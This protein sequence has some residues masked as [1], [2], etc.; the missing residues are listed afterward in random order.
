MA[1]ELN[2]GGAPAAPA[3]WLQRGA[4]VPDSS[5]A[6]LQ[7]FFD[8]C[9]TLQGFTASLTFDAVDGFLTALAALPQPPATDEWLPQLC[10]D[11]FDRAF[12][13][14]ESATKARGALERRLA[15]LCAQLDP[16]AMLDDP[17]AL[18]LAP[19]MAEYTDED[20][21][22]LQA[23]GLSETDAALFQTGM[24]WA[25]GFF[26]A[27][28]LF[29]AAWTP[30]PGEEPAAAFSVAFAQI[31]ALRMAPDEE[32]WK[33]HLATYWPKEPPTR[34]DL[35]TEVCF[36]VQD[37]RLFWVDF[38]PVTAPRKAEALPGRNDLC[39]CGSG[40]KFKKC[41]GAAA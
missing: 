1:D 33:A 34:D 39:H 16:A 32:E 24:P 2:P 9:E 21:R 40:K 8:T 20:R 13:D 15:V 18:R 36:A 17:E 28:R 12:A 26:E 6:D 29:E 35:I 23:E 4:S 10:G 3:P 22:Q 41:H 27:V 31:D 14:P 37:L 30:P 19:L 5:E 25:E 7:A 11:G 38:A